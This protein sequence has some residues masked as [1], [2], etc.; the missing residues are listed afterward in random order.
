M[1]EDRIQD[2]LNELKQKNPVI[3]QAHIY[4]DRHEGGF[5]GLTDGANYLFIKSAT[6]D[7]AKNYFLEEV[8]S[9]FG[10]EVKG[11]F[12]LFGVFDPC[13]NSSKIIN[14]LMGQ[15]DAHVDIKLIDIGDNS[16]AIYMRETGEQLKDECNIICIQFELTTYASNCFGASDSCITKESCC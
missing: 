11:N 13:Y 14:V 8:E 16:E 7:E 5:E 10:Y 3:T 4:D 2:L 6:D 12:Y 15:L 9:C 1:V